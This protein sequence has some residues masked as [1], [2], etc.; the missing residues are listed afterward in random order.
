MQG[1]K[2]F[3]QLSLNITLE[4]TFKIIF[5]L[6]LVFLGLRVYGAIGG[7]LI[8]SVI[9]FGI[10]FIP[11][12][13]IMHSGEKKFELINLNEYSRPTIFITAAIV[14]FSSI[15]IL[16]AQIIFKTDPEMVGFYAISSILG[17]IVMWACVPIGKAMFP[18]TAESKEQS[19]KNKK[20]FATSLS[21][22]SLIVVFASIF[23]YF[24]SD[25]A[26]R[27]F[28]G[29]YISEASTVLPYLVVAFGIVAIANL[30]LLY[31]LS[32]GNIKGYQSLGI[33][34]IIESILFLVLKNSITSFAISFLL[35]SV[36]L[37][38]W[39]LFFIRA[40]RHI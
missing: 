1:Q 17:K 24:F 40:K 3:T 31:K 9:A 15:D 32:I 16:F 38:L 19:Q 29:R 20:I 14:V 34:V 5:G 27:L 26:V 28:S 33:C 39:T 12:K 8:G 25:L 11:L 18:L 36:I 13:K 21:L 30:I 10:S 2:K 37:L 6:I 4:A 23:F 35:S 7:F 22:I